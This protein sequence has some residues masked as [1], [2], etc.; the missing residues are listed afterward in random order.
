MHFLEERTTL[1][2]VIDV[3]KAQKQKGGVTM[4]LGNMDC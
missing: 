1:C 2:T 3:E 4:N